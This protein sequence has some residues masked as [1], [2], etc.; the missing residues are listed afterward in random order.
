MLYLTPTPEV[1]DTIARASKLHDL[2]SIQ[3]RLAA[4][5]SKHMSIFTACEELRISYPAYYAL[6]SEEGKRPG[7][8]GP[9]DS[10]DMFNLLKPTQQGRGRVEGFFP[11][12]MRVFT[13]T[14]GRDGWDYEWKW[15]PE[16]KAKEK[17]VFEYSKGSV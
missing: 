13:E 9:A 2:Q 11:K 8:G 7:D 12:E 15:V 16:E 10:K 1:H 17:V 14:A 6:A 4:L 5:R 3:T